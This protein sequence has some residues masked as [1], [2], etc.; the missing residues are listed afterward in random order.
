LLKLNQENPNIITVF[1]IQD[2]N[3]LKKLFPKDYST[4]FQICDL[5]CPKALENFSGELRIR[6]PKELHQKLAENAAMQGVSL[7]TYITYELT[8]ITSIGVGEDS[9]EINSNTVY[10][11]RA[12]QEL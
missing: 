2:L 4:I 8:K 7:N 5:E 9:Y 10:P 12:I 3:E 6:F 1:I 11:H